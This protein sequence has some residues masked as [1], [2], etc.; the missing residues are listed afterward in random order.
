M[1]FASAVAARR[2]PLMSDNNCNAYGNAEEGLINP[3][4]QSAAIP[5]GSGRRPYGPL[6]AAVCTVL[7]LSAPLTVS[8]EPA[9]D[10]PNSSSVIQQNMQD[11][12]RAAG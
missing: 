10:K 3:Y 1:A 12:N 9:A 11:N 4:S 6:A 8:A 2:A 7:L 5:I